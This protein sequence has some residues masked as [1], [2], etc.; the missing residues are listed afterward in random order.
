MCQINTAKAKTRLGYLNVVGRAE[1]MD[2]F[3]RLFEPTAGS[4]EI[5]RLVKS[6]ILKRRF[7]DAKNVNSIR[8]NKIFN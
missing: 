7:V 5:S 1:K 8:T 2:I 6:I 4:V 3:C